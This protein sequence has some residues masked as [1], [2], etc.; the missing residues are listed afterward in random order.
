M[1]GNVN[2]NQPV[3][4]N[5]NQPPPPPNW[6]ARTPLNLAASLHNLPA[7]PE[8]YLPKFDPTEVID[9]ENHLQIFFSS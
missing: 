2:A 4:P 9:V 5:A 1:V 8:K 3:N 6:K 7:H